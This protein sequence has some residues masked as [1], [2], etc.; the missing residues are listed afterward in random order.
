MPVISR[1]YGIIIIMYFN[2]HNPPHI[3]AKYAGHEAIFNFNEDVIEG[4][5]P[6]RAIK[7][8]QEWMQQHQDELIDNWEKARRGE[9][10]NT[11]APLE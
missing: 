10:L 5:L 9:P 3:H 8:V 2:D 11:I 6:T 7:F 4:K 1:F